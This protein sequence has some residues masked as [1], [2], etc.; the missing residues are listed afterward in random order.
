MT[1]ALSEDVTFTELLAYYHKTLDRESFFADLLRPLQTLRSSCCCR[2]SFESVAE[3]LEMVGL[4][5]AASDVMEFAQSL[6]HKWELPYTPTNYS[7]EQYHKRAMAEAK[8]EWE[9]KQ[10]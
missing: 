9:A 6:P 5:S 3:E 7:D 1:H 10:P 2:Q 8:A 4:K